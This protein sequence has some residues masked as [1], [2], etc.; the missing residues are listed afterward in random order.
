MS[1]FA[2]IFWSDLQLM[3]SLLMGSRRILKVL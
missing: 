3:N 2:A 1:R